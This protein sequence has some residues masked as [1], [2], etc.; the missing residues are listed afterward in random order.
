VAISGPT[1]GAAQVDYDFTATVSPGTTTQPITYVWEA[2]DQ[3]PVTHTGGDLDDTVT[4]NWDTPGLK[5]INVTASNAVGSATDTH[6]VTINYV[7]PSS[8]DIAGPTTGITQTIYAF[9]ATVSP[10]TTT[11]PITYVWEATDQT[12]VTHTGGDLDDTI[13]FTWNVTGT[14]T[15]T[16]TA[17]NITNIGVTHVHDITIDDAQGSSVYLPIIIKND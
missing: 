16:V 12:P 3:A 7:P 6:E 10:G 5:T 2:T 14:K 4:F 15:I 8:V 13:N 11:Q 9:T 1:T 17:T